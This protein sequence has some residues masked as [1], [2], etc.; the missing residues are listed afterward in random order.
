LSIPPFW[1][2][3]AK[4][5]IYNISQFETIPDV[6]KACDLFVKFCEAKYHEAKVRLQ[7]NYIELM[8]F[9]DFPAQHWPSIHTI[10]PSRLHFTI[11]S[12]STQRAKGVCTAIKS[13]QIMFKLG[14]CADHIWRKLRCFDNPAEVP[15]GVVGRDGIETSPKGQLAALPTL[16]N[17]KLDKSWMLKLL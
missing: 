7:K 16:S 3:T 4:V 17:N 10:L 11:I 1:G 9:F 8:Y 6:G 13:L 12:H 14:Q 5:A 15:T 2:P